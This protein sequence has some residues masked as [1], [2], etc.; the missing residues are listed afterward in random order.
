ME[1][2]SISRGIALVNFFHGVKYMQHEEFLDL[3]HHVMRS[4]ENK[5]SLQNVPPCFAYSRS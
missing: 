5:L 2:S 4:G 1:L 3:G